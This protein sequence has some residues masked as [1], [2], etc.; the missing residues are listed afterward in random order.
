MRQLA[1]AAGAASSGGRFRI[2]GVGKMRMAVLQHVPFEG[3]AAIAEWAEARGI[4]TT[5][6][7]LHRGDALPELARVRYADRDGR[8]DER[9]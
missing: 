7:H 9:E 3:P 8:P 4:P 6:T 1:G 2:I 5:V